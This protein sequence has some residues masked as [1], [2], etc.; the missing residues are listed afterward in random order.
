MEKLVLPD[1]YHAAKVFRFFFKVKGG[2]KLK[3]V[4][5]RLGFK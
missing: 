1:L 5:G 4:K 3:L 2:K